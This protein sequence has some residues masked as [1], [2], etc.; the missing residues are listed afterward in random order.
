[1]GEY[2]PTCGHEIRV[3]QGGEGTAHYE[4]VEEQAGYV[5]ADLPPSTL[6]TYNPD[7]EKLR[8]VRGKMTLIYRDSTM[9]WADEAEALNDIIR[10]LDA[11]LSQGGKDGK[12]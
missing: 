2:C 12:P 4:P 5:R 11:Y 7:R 10:D 3:V 9:S 8:E 1:M 6:T